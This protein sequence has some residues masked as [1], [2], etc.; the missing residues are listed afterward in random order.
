MSQIST[1]FLG[2]VTG[3]FATSSLILVAELLQFTDIL[4][5]I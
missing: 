1:Y 2:F 5:F 3:A 4:T